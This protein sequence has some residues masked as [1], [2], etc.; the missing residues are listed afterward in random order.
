MSITLAFN[1]DN[2]RPTL[3]D[4]FPVSN[5]PPKL[6]T[7][8]PLPEKEFAFDVPVNGKPIAIW[9]NIETGA[10]FYLAKDADGK[11]AAQYGLAGHIYEGTLGK[12]DTPNLNA[13]NANTKLLIAGT[14]QHQVN[15]N[16]LSP[17]DRSFNNPQFAP[18]K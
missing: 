18:E 3:G 6:N 8:T 14:V 2:I 1:P 16:K 5:K 11:I 15:A 13:P 7:S 17:L 12:P 4:S 10:Y 9:R